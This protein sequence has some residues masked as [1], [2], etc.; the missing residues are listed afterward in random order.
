MVHN[1]TLRRV[2]GRAS[3]HRVLY[4]AMSGF[5]VMLATTPLAAPAQAQSVTPQSAPTVGGVVDTNGFTAPSNL[6]LGAVLSTGTGEVASLATT[7]GTAPYNAP[8]LTPLNSRSR[9]RWSATHDS[10]HAEQ[11]GELCRRRPP[12]AVGEPDQPGRRGAQRNQR[13]DHPRLPGRPVQRHDRRHSH[14]DSNDFTHHSTSFFTNEEI[15]QLVVDRGPGTAETLGDA[16]FGGTMSIRTID[17]AATTTFTPYASYG[18]YNTNVEGLRIDSGAIQEANGASAVFNVQRDNSNGALTNINQNR[19]NFFGKI[20]VPVGNSSTLTFLADSNNLYQNPP[21]G[22]TL[23]EMQKF[24]HNFGLSDDPNSQSFFKFNF[25]K[26]TTDMEYVDLA[27]HLADGWE[28]DGKVY[29]YAYYHADNNGDDIN[30]DTIGAEKNEVQLSPGGAIIAGVPGQTFL[31]D[32]RSVG[33]IQ[34]LQKD[35][36]WGDVKTGFW[37][38]HQVNSRFL[39]ENDLS[40]GNLPNFDVWQRWEQGHCR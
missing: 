5:G 37:F 12:D 13:S 15:G 3:S 16:T 34:R 35:F 25:D 33:T 36:A 18:S 4:L 20:V 7:P 9:P 39:A 2:L 24:G 28:Y 10:E 26:I 19:G 32:Y 6:D 17:P 29:T 21:I 30:D 22:A 8:S 27:S 23:S 1:F 40:D 38:D 14:G 31:N 11:H